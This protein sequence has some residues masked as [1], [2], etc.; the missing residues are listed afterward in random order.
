VNDTSSSEFS[1]FSDLF[2]SLKGLQ[3]LT[4]VHNP[5]QHTPFE[6]KSYIWPKMMKAVTALAKYSSSEPP[7]LNQAKVLARW[8]QYKSDLNPSLMS[9]RDYKRYCW[10]P[11]I[12]VDSKF[13]ELVVENKIPITLSSLRGLLY[14]YHEKFISLS[15]DHKFG[16]TLC[17]LL[18]SKASANNIVN[19]WHAHA[20]SLIGESAPQS[21]A[22]IAASD[23]E[24]PEKKLEEFEINRTTEFAQRFASEMALLAAASF[25]YISEV[26]L[27]KIIR[28]VL[29][30]N[31]VGRE[32]Y[33]TAISDI[34]LSKRANQ[35]EEIQGML[36]DFFLKNRGLGDPRVNPDNWV[37]VRSGAKAR[38]IEWLSREDINLF[39]ELILR[40]RHDKHGRKSFWL[41]YIGKIS[42]SRALLSPDD[43]R[44]NAVRLNELQE[45]GRSYGELIGT[46]LA[47]AFVLDFGQIVV[48]EFSQVGNACYIYEKAAFEEIIDDFWTKKVQFSVLKSKRLALERIL[49]NQ[50][51]WKIEARHIL[52]SF[53]IR[54]V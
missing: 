37:G 35:N 11:D 14:S 34:I 43:L 45:K 53:G 1:L 42:R 51:N 38:V 20:D 27:N 40:D 52:A 50:N 48:V 16:S 5:R 23:W 18:S 9:A 24:L 10:V 47:S 13:K 8:A 46:S 22:K 54:R 30:S 6:G 49:H 41:E 32:D 29:C 26:F 33:K 28:G 31:L 19:K 15:K 36:I 3:N 4:L 7:N 21:F 39:F 25:D 17:A 12:V 2:N 44:L